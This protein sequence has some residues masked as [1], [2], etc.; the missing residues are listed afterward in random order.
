MQRYYY[1][2]RFAIPTYND[3]GGR[4]GSSEIM[5]TTG[6]HLSQI[7]IRLQIHFFED[8]KE[9][10]SSKNLNDT[11]L[12]TTEMIIADYNNRAINHKKEDLAWKFQFFSLSLR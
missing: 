5:T 3:F 10:S 7:N 11:H 2:D 12:M 6:N 1:L 4:E 8:K 9:K